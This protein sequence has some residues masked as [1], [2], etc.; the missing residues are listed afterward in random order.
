MNNQERSFPRRTILKAGG[1]LAASVAV[2]AFVPSRLLGATAPSNRVA[3]A[4]IGVGGQGG[5]MLPSFLGRVHHKFRTP[6]LTIFAMW[7]IT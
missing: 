1:A 7:A 5:G 6:P 3:L 4:H 2:P